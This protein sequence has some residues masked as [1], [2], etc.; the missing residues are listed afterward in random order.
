M[1]DASARGPA[2]IA[3]AVFGANIVAKALFLL[4]T[5][6][7]WDQEMPSW[8]LAHQ[9]FD[10]AQT[11]V[12]LTV[13]YAIGM[14]P[15]EALRGNRRASLLLLGGALFAM[16]LFAEELHQRYFQVAL[17]LVILGGAHLIRSRWRGAAIGAL[18]TVLAAHLIIWVSR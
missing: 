18:G 1:A 4:L 11:V 5:P 14:S 3:G 12:S 16:A 13:I 6:M 2:G 8:L 9:V 7:P 10:Y 15:L 17:P